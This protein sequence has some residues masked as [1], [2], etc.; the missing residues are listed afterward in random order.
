MNNKN[1]QKELDIICRSFSIKVNSREQ[2]MEEG[3]GCGDEYNILFFSI[4]E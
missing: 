2:A 1:I 4:K 3:R